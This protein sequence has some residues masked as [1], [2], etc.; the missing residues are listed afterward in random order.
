MKSC[1]GVSVSPQLGHLPAAG[2]ELWHPRR[3]EK[4]QSEPAGHR[5]TEG[6]GEVEARQDWHPWGQG[7][8]ERQAGRTLWEELERSGGRLPCPLG[9]G[10]PAEFPGQSPALQGSPPPGRIGPGGHRKEAGEIR[11][12]R[13]EGPSQTRRARE[14]RRAFAPP[15]QAQEACWAPRWG[16]LPSETR[17][18][19]HTWVPP[20]PW[21]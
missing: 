5:G 1:G 16:P 9:H 4:P 15:T 12:G 2:G 17:S 6:G 8:Q 10:E 13:W 3:R 20:V 21:A 19:G 14:E 18:G 11:R 7:N